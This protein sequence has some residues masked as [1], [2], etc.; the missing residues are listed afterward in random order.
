MIIILKQW[1]GEGSSRE[2]GPQEEIPELTAHRSALCYDYVIN[3][4]ILWWHLFHFGRSA[5]RF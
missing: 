3:L 4:Y 2:P 1:E 5:E